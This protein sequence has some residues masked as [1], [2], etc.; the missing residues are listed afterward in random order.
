MVSPQLVTGKI[1]VNGCLLAG[2]KGRLPAPFRFPGAPLLGGLNSMGL[3][4]V[5]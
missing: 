4:A 5:F 3:N 1:A 2:D